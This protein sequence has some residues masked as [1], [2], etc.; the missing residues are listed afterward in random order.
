MHQVRPLRHDAVE[1]ALASSATRHIISQCIRE[2][3]AVRDLSNRTGLP[4]ASAYRHVARLVE[5]QIL[6]IE[7]SAMTADGKPFDLYRSRIRFARVEV[8]PEKVQVVWEPNVA[9][10]DRLINMWNNFGD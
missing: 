3:R 7:R 10:E 6:V 5:D 1:N 9:L 2:A 8:G 4:L